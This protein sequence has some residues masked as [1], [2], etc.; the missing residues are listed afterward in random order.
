MQIIYA[1][2]NNICIHRSYALCNQR[3]SNPLRLIPEGIRPEWQAWTLL[4][5]VSGNYYRYQHIG[6]IDYRFKT[7][8]QHCNTWNR[9]NPI[10]KF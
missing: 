6:L 3:G 1:Y 8:D 7:D 9:H 2:I 10:F 4:A 5:F